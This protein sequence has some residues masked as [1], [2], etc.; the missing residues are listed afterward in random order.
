[1]CLGW[2]GFPGWPGPAGG[3]GAPGRG[4]C[5]RL[6]GG[7]PDEPGRRRWTVAVVPAQVATTAL[8]RHCRP[9]DSTRYFAVVRRRAVLRWWAS[10]WDTC[11]GSRWKRTDARHGEEPNERE[12][13]SL[14][15]VQAR[16]E[17]RGSGV[18]V[19]HPGFELDVRQP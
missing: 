4:G 11:S 14:L 3:A 13:A 12:P 17:G 18:L 1:M 2:P 15:V 5:A 9:D 19:E 7:G 10:G 8:N 16:V 6:G